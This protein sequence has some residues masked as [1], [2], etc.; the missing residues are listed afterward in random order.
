MNRLYLVR[1]GE[2]R[3][4]VTKE[5]S[6][7]QVDYS[8]TP[9][10]VLQSRQTAE[11][12]RDKEIHEVF[13]SPLKR[14]M[15]T[16]E[17]IAGPLGLKVVVVDSFRE[18]DVGDL[19]LQPPSAEAW[20]FHDAILSGWLSDRPEQAFLGGENYVMLWNRVRTGIERIVAD[21]E[22]RR[23]VVVAHGGV[24]TFTLRD[25]CRDIDVEW[26]RTA[27]NHNCSITVVD[28]EL[29]DGQL[30]G[31]LITWASIAHLHGAAAD[32]VPGTP[33]PGFA[34]DE[35]TDQRNAEGMP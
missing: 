14:A 32:L 7:R 12:F 6:C 34:F 25:L 33:Q 3:A 9:K 4:N 18:V 22:G 23:I 1:H 20:A 24:F 17:I 29:R 11:F 26:L 31:K 2:N 16:A 21:K 19:E 35:A 27:A 30:E 13:S 15:E 28:V 5:F 8:L 10:G